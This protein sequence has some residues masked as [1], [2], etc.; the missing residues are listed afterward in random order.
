[1]LN[2]WE[3]KKERPNLKAIQNRTPTMNFRGGKMGRL[4]MAKGYPEK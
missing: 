3:G 1:M 4:L 2:P